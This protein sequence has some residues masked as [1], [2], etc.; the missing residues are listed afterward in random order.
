MVSN[1]N[2]GGVLPRRP[3]RRRHE[4]GPQLRHHC[5][6]SLNVI[7]LALQQA[8]LGLGPGALGALWK[9]GRTLSTGGASS[10]HGLADSDRIFTN[11]Y[12]R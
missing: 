1:E 12:G 11:L 7:M 5:W 10:T 9:L 2:H 8:G 6:R 4:R 3:P